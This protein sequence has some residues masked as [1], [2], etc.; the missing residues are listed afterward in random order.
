MLESA[1]DLFDYAAALTP[2]VICLHR[3]RSGFAQRLLPSPAGV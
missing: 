1:E 3:A 2:F